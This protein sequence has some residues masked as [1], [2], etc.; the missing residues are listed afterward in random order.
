MTTSNLADFPLDATAPAEHLRR[1]AA[2]VRVHFTWWGVHKTLTARQKEE[3]GLACQAD[4]RLL[5]AGKMLLMRLAWARPGSRVSFGRRS[6]CSSQTSTSTS[7]ISP[8]SSSAARG[9]WSSSPNRFATSPAVAGRSAAS[10]STHAA[11]SAICPAGT[12]FSASLLDHCTPL[13][14]GIR[15]LFL[16]SYSPNLN[17]IERLWGFAKRQ[18]VYG[19]YHPDFASFRAAIEST[20]ANLSTTH[21]NR[22]QSLMTLN[23]QEFDD[24]SLLAAQGIAKGKTLE[25]GKGSGKSNPLW[26]LIGADKN[27]LREMMTK[28]GFEIRIWWRHEPEARK[29]DRSAFEWVQDEQKISVKVLLKSEN[30]SVDGSSRCSHARSPGTG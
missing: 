13:G 18:S 12:P 9:R 21:A 2:A 4:G 8:A 1:V 6:A 7:A 15:L 24:V 17:L 22:L 11:S 30:S 16:P 10:G 27:K 28:I 29:K 20:F 5:T 23:F 26:T 3:V 14:A 19:K 25:L